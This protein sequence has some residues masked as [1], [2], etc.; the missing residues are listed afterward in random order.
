MKKLTTIFIALAFFAFVGTA[1]AAKPSINVLSPSNSDITTTSIRIT[2]S[3]QENGSDTEMMIQYT[4]DPGFGSGVVSIPSSFELTSTRNSGYFIKTITGL[5]PSMNYYIRAIATNNDG[6]ITD[7]GIVV[8]TDSGNP[9][10]TP[11]IETLGEESVTT[12]SMTLTGRVNTYGAVGTAYYKLYNSNCTSLI[13]TT[14]STSLTATTGSQYVRN[15]VS[16]LSAGV[17][18]CAELIANINGVNYP[19]GKVIVKT[20]PGSTIPPTST[21]VINSFYSDASSVYTGE[22]TTLRWSTTGCVSAMITPGGTVS[23]DGSKVIYPTSTT[24]Y[25]LDAWGSGTYFDYDKQKT[26]SV[27]VLP[28]ENNNTKPDCYYNSTCYWNG[29][30]W[31]TYPVNPTPTNPSCY[32]NS[33]CYWNG[34][35]WVYYSV[36]PTPNPNPNPTYPSCYYNSTCYYNG[37]NWVYKNNTVLDNYSY[38]P[39]TPYTGGPNYVYKTLHGEVKTVYIDQQVQGE[40]INQVVTQP[41]DYT[42]Y[43]NGYNSDI[44]NRYPNANYE[45]NNLNNRVLLTGAAGNTG[46]ITLLGLLI[47]LIIIGIIVYFVKARERRELH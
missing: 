7:P 32:Y 1:F 19:G 31:V 45:N 30:S 37:T 8:Q 13:T 42:Y 15:S 25:T 18:Y 34:T 4:T 24:S 40:P 28:K 20:Y 27:G 35:T 11:R 26:I 5:T 21:C 33:T 36:N 22:S 14:G 44:M 17:S 47:A 46:R 10:S 3:Y 43:N 41:I 38:N 16:G 6:P 39:H 2:V 29:S 9:T 12:A 23:V